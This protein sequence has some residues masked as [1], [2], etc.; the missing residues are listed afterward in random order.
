MRDVA[1]FPIKLQP[2]LKYR[3]KKIYFVHTFVYVVQHQGKGKGHL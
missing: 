2:Y 3:R 1:L